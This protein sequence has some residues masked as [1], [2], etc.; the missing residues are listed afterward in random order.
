MGQALQAY[1]AVAG[2]KRL[3]LGLHGHAPSTFPAADTGVMLAEGATF[4]DLHLRGV[5]VTLDPLPVAISPEQFHGSPVRFAA[6]PKPVT[7]PFRCAGP[8]PSMP[9]CWHSSWDVCPPNGGCGN[10]GVQ[11]PP[12]MVRRSIVRM[13]P[14]ERRRLAIAER[15][16][17]AAVISRENKSGGGPLT[18]Q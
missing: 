8:P 16:W 18:W 3:W 15:P 14:S 11:T 2:P 17:K 5:P 1:N 12:G 7:Q 9:G 13:V 6:P 4:F 10:I